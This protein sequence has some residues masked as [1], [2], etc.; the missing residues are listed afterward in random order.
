[1]GRNL[2]DFS[3][4]SESRARMVADQLLRRGIRDS[5]VLE[6]MRS[7]PRHAFVPKARLKAAY[8]D[9]PLD[10]GH[11][12]TI[13]QPYMVALMTELLE[14]EPADR[15]LEIG[16]GS[17]YQTAVLCALAS[18]VDSIERIAALA[19]AARARLPEL[20]ITNATIITGDGTVSSPSPT[21]YDAILVTAGAPHIPMAL[22]EQ[23]REGG[24]LVCPVGPRDVQEL[25]VVTREGAAFR[26]R[27][28]IRCVF[29]PLIGRDGWD[30]GRFAP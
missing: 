2:V 25:V 5:R 21:P 23:L 17:G 6:A 30:S 11:G 16:T 12:Q 3:G 24:R 1:M 13:S 10:I 9:R 15:V 7:V 19:A 20:G 18:H 22:R 26:E 14:L 29:V 4:F 27:R 28:D 8:D